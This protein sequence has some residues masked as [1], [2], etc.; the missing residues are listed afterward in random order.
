MNRVK[1]AQ[2]FVMNSKGAEKKVSPFD[3]R[4]TSNLSS[5]KRRFL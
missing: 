5:E 4:R 2:K 1:N 3:S